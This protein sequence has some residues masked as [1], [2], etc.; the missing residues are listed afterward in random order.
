MKRLLLTLGLAA[1]WATLLPAAPY[2]DRFV[3]IFGWN[4][5]RD[6][7][8]PDITQV[9][10][11]AARHGLNGAV[12]SLG[13]DTLCKKSPDYFRRLEQVQ[14]AC[15]TNHLEFIPAIFSVGY[16]GAA[17]AHDRNLAEGVP[18]HDAPF[19]VKNGEARLVPDET[20]RLVNGGFEDFTGHRLKGFNFH[21]Q[22]G[23][24]SFVD[25][26]I[27]HGG[28][29]ALRLANFTA[30]AHGHGRVMQE[31]R[32]RPHRCYRVR[33]WVKTDGLRPASAFRTLA[34]AGPRE[35][36][37]RSFNLPATTD[38][39]QLTMV[40][41]SLGEEKVRLYAGIWGGQAGKVWLDDWSVEELGP[42]NVLRRPGTPVSVRNAD[43]TGT[44]TEG[45]D[46]APLVDPNYSPYNV[47]RAAPPLK[48]LPGGR[49]KAGQTLRV[50]WYHPMVI[51]DSQITVCMA[52]PA[53]YEI[54]EHEAKLLAE[55]LRPRRVL[56]NMDEIRMGGTCAACRGRNMG[57]LLGECI[58]R[59]TQILRRHLPGAEIYIWSD[60]LDPNHNARGRYYLVDGDY[61]GSWKHV[62][63]DLIMA[64]W[65]GAP[66]EKSL[67]FCADEGFRTLVACYYDAD[68]LN[69]VKRWLELAGRTPNVRGFM[70]TPWQK[71]YT[72]LPAFGDLLQ[73][74]R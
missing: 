43:G 52:E 27:K 42:L 22:P 23:E 49:I 15:E 58:T 30:N 5:N 51:N 66:R 35:L 24:I 73:A 72:L 11:P 37:P 13:L 39:R 26:E 70:Y 17:L 46:Y 3:W 54:F 31:I 56:L 53:L 1:A 28:Q 14:R 8:V 29:A 19:L 57:E 25:R 55:R 16:G 40:F 32:V 33:L 41:N 59:Q 62:P 36:A 71:K 2:A 61:T 48:T 45:R 47:D 38:W 18:V 63:K 65:G 6:T 50:S 4:L 12:L 74:G 20:V 60:M 64:V 44:Y 9:L 7:D 10:E 21:D 69:D 67:R 68:D 34:L